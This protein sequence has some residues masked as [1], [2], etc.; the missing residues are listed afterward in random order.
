VV[1]GALFAP[2]TALLYDGDQIYVEKVLT[3]SAAHVERQTVRVG[4]VDKGR[5]Q[6]LDGL[7][8]GDEVRLK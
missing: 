6:I 7:N 3:S 5:A 4:I 2:E 8:E 1:D